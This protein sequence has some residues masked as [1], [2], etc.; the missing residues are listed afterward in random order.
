M[1][2]GCANTTRAYDRIPANKTLLIYCAAENTFGLQLQ[3]STAVIQAL[4]DAPSPNKSSA[5]PAAVR[6]LVRVLRSCERRFIRHQAL[7]R[8]GM[9]GGACVGDRLA[10]ARGDHH[11]R[12]GR[13]GGCA[14]KP[15]WRVLPARWRD[16]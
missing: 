12:I 2:R 7:R 4:I 13:G 8:T 14:E 10:L 6:R 16:Q 5:C 11:R 15:Q 9:Q 1:Q 3:Q